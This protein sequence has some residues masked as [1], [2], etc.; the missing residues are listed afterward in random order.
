MM[1]LEKFEEAAEAVKKVVNP[2]K[3]VYSEYFSAQSGNKVYLK[4]ENM[5]STKMVLAKH[6]LL[7]QQNVITNQKMELVLQTTFNQKDSFQLLN[8]VTE[9]TT[10]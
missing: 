2:T 10:T 4:P 8:L 6:T 1:T 7:Q 9:Y 3:L 5:Q